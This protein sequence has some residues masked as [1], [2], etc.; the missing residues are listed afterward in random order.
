MM[1]QIKHILLAIIISTIK[2]AIAATVDVV[3]TGADGRP[4][5]YAVVEIVTDNPAGDAAMT[6]RL[7]GTGIIDQRDETFLPLVTLLRQGGQITFTNND[8]TRHQVYSFSTIKHFAYEINKGHQSPPVIFDIPGVAAIGCNIHDHMVTFVYVAA[9]PWALLTDQDGHG[10]IN[11]VPPGKYFVKLWH[12]QLLPA[13]KQ[14]KEPI[15]VTGTSFR[16]KF[17]LPLMP[18]ELPGKKHPHAGDY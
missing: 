16:T 14:P 3:V 1:Q 5:P 8:H 11:E 18:G 15:L 10:Q 12:P 13:Y 9:S 17:S 4:A 7:S 6:S 2:P